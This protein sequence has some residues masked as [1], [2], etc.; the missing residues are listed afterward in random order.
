MLKSARPYILLHLILLLNSF[1]GICSKTAAGMPFFS[2]KWMLIYGII[3]LIMAVYAVLWQ[4]VLKKLPLNV[5]YANKAVSVIWGML[6]GVVL[7]N[8]AITLNNIIGAVIV[9]AGVILMVTGGEK[10]E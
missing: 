10:N 6:W 5:A 3:L 2:L 4:Q 9:I 8:E 7:F 1:A